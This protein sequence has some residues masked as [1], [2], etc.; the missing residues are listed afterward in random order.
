MRPTPAEQVA[1]DA[2]A[3][4]FAQREPEVEALTGGLGNRSWRMRDAGRDLVV[5]LGNER[6]GAYGVDRGG[7]IAAQSLAAG[8]GLAPAVLWHDAAAGLLVTEFVPGRVWSKEAARDPL[9]AARVGEWL[10]RLHQLPLSAGMARIDFCERAVLLGQS[11]KQGSAPQALQERAAGERSRLGDSTSPVLCHHDL[12]HLNM[13]DSGAGLIVLDW[14]YA[15]AGEPLMDL[16][17]YVAYHDLGEP[18]IAALLAGYALEADEACRV[19]L[20]AAR[21]LFEFVW[22]LWL[23]ARRTVEASESAGLAA[24]RRRLA[25]RLAANP[26]G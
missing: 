7:E 4:R 18:A 14:E 6:A 25:A 12:H 5:R 9:A 24:V 11:L 1:L 2:V 8:Q 19:R 16:A 23:E 20:A 22:L 17:G 15:G 3:A 10:Y 26:G 21:W 13:I